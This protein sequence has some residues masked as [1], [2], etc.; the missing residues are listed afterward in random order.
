MRTGS[1]SISSC[2]CCDCGLA[3]RD[4]WSG[5]LTSTEDWCVVIDV[6]DCDGEGT[7]GCVSRRCGVACQYDDSA[8]VG[9]R[10]ATR[11]LEVSSTTCDEPQHARVNLEQAV[12]VG[13]DSVGRGVAVSS[14][15]VS[16]AQSRDIARALV[17]RLAGRGSPYR[18]LVVDV[19]NRDSEAFHIGSVAAISDL[20]VDRVG[21]RGLVIEAR[22][23]SYL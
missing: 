17:H 23:G 18:G 11:A 9:A 20:H 14:V 12:V 15:T 8:G 13:G 6:T 3:F 21:G 7:A 4:T 1:V 2:V 16:D 10:S 22:A 19:G 5:C